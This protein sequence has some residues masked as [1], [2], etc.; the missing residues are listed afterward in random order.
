[1]LTKN[2]FIY[3]ADIIFV[4]IFFA[5]F[6]Y[7]EEQKLTADYLYY[8]FCTILTALV[9]FRPIGLSVDDENYQ[10]MLDLIRRM[11]LDD[12]WVYFERDMLYFAPV[13][14]LETIFGDRAMIVFSGGVFLFK[15]V[16]LGILVKNKIYALFAYYSMSYFLQDI[17]QFRLSLAVLIVMV[18]IYFFSRS[19]LIYSMVALL[20][21]G[22]AHYSGF[23]A[24]ALFI[25]HVKFYRYLYIL[26]IVIFGLKYIGILGLL[27]K[28]VVLV[29]PDVSYISRHLQDEYTMNE[30]EF[31]LTHMFLYI[32]IIGS[33]RNIYENKISTIGI[34]SLGLSALAIGIFQDAITLAVRFNEMFAA[35]YMLNIGFLSNS[36]NRN[37][38]IFLLISV[39]LFYIRSR[40]IGLL[41]V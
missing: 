29:A 5:A 6:F 15:M 4:A 14:L 17:I 35:F 10:I 30:A 12:M 41:L 34:Y 21:S 38:K 25:K 31:Y 26:P 18:S 40:Y 9:V 1:M 19:S 22:F 2:L 24:I 27:S 37:A 11:D 23:S 33:A 39:A 36:I 32:A 3:S 28:Y 7:K 16:L 20:L 13:W 8:F